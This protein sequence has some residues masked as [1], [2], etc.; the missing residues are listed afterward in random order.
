MVTLYL[1]VLLGGIGPHVAPPPATQAPEA[2]ALGWLA[3]EVPRWKKENRC[4]SCHHN[5]DAARTLYLAV[6]AGHRVERAALADTTAW[7]SRPEGWDRNGG[8][9][10]FSDK[11]QARLQFASALA[12][13][14][15]AGLV[16]DKRPLE[17]AARLVA[18]LQD[19]DGAWRVLA[20]GTIGAPATHGTALAT[21]LARRTLQVAGADRY[22]DAIRKSE[23]WLRR[24]PV[25]TVLDAAAVLLALGRASD[26][27]A[28]AKKRRCLEL[29]RRG[30]TREGGWGP[31]VHSAPE[32]FDTAVVLLA[33]VEQERTAEIS[34][35]IARGRA[36][37][38][39]EQEPEGSW[40]E[41]T[42]PAGA[43]SYAQKLSTTGWAARALLATAK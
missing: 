15:A 27:E 12:E 33:L 10:P 35:W 14:H 7:L 4:Y 42:R 18:D 2:K 16:T 17:Q 37:L 21:H 19:K 13:A 39:A 28:M 24:A 5:G 34:G 6:R 32:V 31:Y 25:S 38:L 3:R 11:K 9:G 41:T 1:A 40:P 20:E 30:E 36:H 26:P 22:R 23:N 8:E 43:D 29:I